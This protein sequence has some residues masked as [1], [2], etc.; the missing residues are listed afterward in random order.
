MENGMK[1]LLVLSSS[2]TAFVAALALA[3][4]AAA[5]PDQSFVPFQP[6][7]PVVNGCPAGLEALQ[8]SDLTPLGYRVP[9]RVDGPANGGNADG[10]VCGRPWTPQEQAARLPGDALVIFDFT[11]NTRTPWH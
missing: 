10:V 6:G 8:V 5:A 7:N 3:T 2:L 1:T 4:G 9:S 11:D